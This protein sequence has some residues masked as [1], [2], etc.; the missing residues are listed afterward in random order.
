MPLGLVTSDF[1]MTQCERQPRSTFLN[2]SSW[3][4][5]SL[6][7]LWPME[8]EGSGGGDS[9]SEREG[10]WDMLPPGPNTSELVDG[11]CEGSSGVAALL[12]LLSLA[13][14]YVTHLS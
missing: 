2:L 8:V 4:V 1:H 12:V 9:S 7:H 13:D 6:L 10:E 14:G 11:W 5:F 3:V